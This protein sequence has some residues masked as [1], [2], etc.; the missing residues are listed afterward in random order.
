[1]F[2][3]RR[4]RTERAPST[5]TPIERRAVL[6]GSAAAAAGVAASQVAP[7]RAAVAHA[8]A[9]PA[10]TAAPGRAMQVGTPIAA[11]DVTVV[12]TGEFDSASTNV[13]AALE[14]LD[15]RLSKL[16]VID[17]L[18]SS[19]V[20]VDDFMGGLPTSGSI[21][22]LGWAFTSV[23]TA[24]AAL[25]SVGAPGVLTLHTGENPLLWAHADLGAGALHGLPELTCEFRLKFN[26][27]NTGTGNPNPFR[28]FFGLHDGT[29]AEPANGLYFRYRNN[30]AKTWEAV[31]AS[32][33]V[34]VAVDTNKSG[35]G[36]PDDPN[37]PNQGNPFSAMAY[38]R[39]RIVCD[40]PDGTS[41]RVRF[42][43]DG[44]PV[45]Q[46]DNVTLSAPYTP[47]VTIYKVGGPDQRQVHIDY[48]ALRVDRSQS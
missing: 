24:A 15:G 47:A 18:Q 39:F 20:L 5:G 29:D 2:H 21:G 4:R 46:F 14:E 27:V 44:E 35:L 41:N 40:R 12:P 25:G 43:I 31:R 3:L 1:M 33:G 28:A 23:G 38:H 9:L 48:F 8:A 26:G 45:A 30:A 7:V 36:N 34:P 19:T 6:I 32:A 11:S 17:D 37:D 16:H 10:R 42:F 22:E 13:Q